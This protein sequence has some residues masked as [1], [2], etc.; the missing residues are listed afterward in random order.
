MEHL[1][2]NPAWNALCSGNNSLSNGNQF[3]KYFSPDVSP[4][5]GLPAATVENFQHL[6]EITPVDGP[7]GLMTPVKVD[8]PQPWKMLREM[9][10]V[11]MVCENPIE[12]PMANQAEIIPLTE[13]NVP[14]MLALTKLT[15][16]GPFLRRTIE[17]GHYRGI[18]KEG[19]LVAMAGQRL[20]PVPYA[21]ISAV[22]THPDHLGKGYAAQ[23]LLDQIRRIKAARQIPFLN[24]LTTNI[25]AIKLYESIGFTVRKEI[26]ISI[27][28]KAER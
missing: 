21:E 24:A 22:C 12:R 10:I 7:F 1:L 13:Q 15:N 16:P 25:R 23:L 4:F 9:D 11:Q 2:D 19:K 5:T 17:M 28:Q 6:H 8:F 27:F 14:E 18:F 26:F 3:A 20:N